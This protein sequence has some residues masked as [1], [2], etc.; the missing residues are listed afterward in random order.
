MIFQLATITCQSFSILFRKKVYG[1]FCDQVHTSVQNGNLGV[2][3]LI[4]LEFP[5]LRYVAW[6]NVIWLR[7]KDI[8]PTCRRLLSLTLL[9]MAD[10]YLCFR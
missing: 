3:L 10:L 8:L 9:Q 1:S 2:F 5:I 6:I 7:L 4:S